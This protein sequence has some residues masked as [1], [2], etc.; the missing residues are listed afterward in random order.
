LKR[1]ASHVS[2][3][4]ARRLLSLLQAARRVYVTGQGASYYLAGMMACGLGGLG[5]DAWAI[6]G[7]PEGLAPLL[8]RIGPND[9]LIG[10]S[11]EDSPE[12]ARALAY[13]RQRGARTVA[14]GYS[15]VSGAAHAAEYALTCAASE[16]SEVRSV[17]ALAVFLDALV[18]ALAMLEPGR[19]GQFALDADEVTRV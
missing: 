11:A 13:A 12:V 19:R 5:L 3:D 8:A 1:A 7:E 16:R 17:G 4:L 6:P 15:A 2:P 9:A 14:V 18:Q 10:I